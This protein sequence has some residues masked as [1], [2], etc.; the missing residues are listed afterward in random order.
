M[1]YSSD[2]GTKKL[3]TWQKQGKME[4]GEQRSCADAKA[5]M[6]RS[7]SLKS[8]IQDQMVALQ[9]K[10]QLIE[11]DHKAYQESTSHT[12]K[13][14]E[15]TIRFLQQENKKL[16]QKLVQEKQIQA[17]R[18]AKAK[19]GKDV[20]QFN[21]SKLHDTIKHFNALCHQAQVRRKCL[22]EMELMLKQKAAV[23]KDNRSIQDLHIQHLL[24]N[25]L[26]EAKIKLKDVKHMSSVYRNIITLLKEEILIFQPQIEQLETEILLFENELK[27]L[28]MMNHNVAT[29][30]DTALAEYQQLKKEYRSKRNSKEQILRNLN[31]Q[32]NEK[33]HF[34]KKQDKSG[35]IIEDQAPTDYDNSLAEKEEVRVRTYEEATEKIKEATGAVNEWEVLQRFR[36]QEEKLKYLEKEKL[37]AESALCDVKDKQEKIAHLLKEIKYSRQARLQT[38]LS[39]NQ[40]TLEDLQARLQLESKDQENF[41]MEFEKIHEVLN[42]ATSEVKRLEIKL[43]FI[44]GSWANFP[45]KDL[46][47]NLP[48]LDIL[49][50]MG[51]KLQNLQTHLEGQDAEEIFR[52]MEEEEFVD[53]IERNLTA[54]NLRISLLSPAKLDE[55]EDEAIGED[56]YLVTRE[57]IKTI[58]E[59]ITISKRKANI[60]CEKWGLSN[61]T[62]D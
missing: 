26:G 54:N 57:N 35:E 15:E 33:R 49:A 8:S 29:S 11:Y 27:D 51:Q 50:N 31:H 55:S 39:N 56:C 46:F 23:R 60:W 43:Q 24:E 41:K 45:V 4:S 16:S 58:S 44:K 59:Q 53:I 9:Q 18:E 12:I 13:E 1:D 28:K 52:E 62:Y 48:V 6:A 32:A 7:S 38:K 40:K 2:T 22:E 47:L 14:R 37:K 17:D 30:R 21:E 5:V 61:I 19:E 34:K 3:R 10:I 25:K 20:L 36:N 42:K